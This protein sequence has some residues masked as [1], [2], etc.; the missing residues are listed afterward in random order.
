MSDERFTA[1]K[2]KLQNFNSEVKQWG[3]NTESNLKGNASYQMQSQNLQSKLRASF[4]KEST[5]WGKR[6]FNIGFSF[7]RE[8][9]FVHYGVG[10][11]YR[12]NNGTVERYAKN[13]TNNPRRP[14]N[15][16]NPVVKQKLPQLDTIVE[17]LGDEL[18]LNST[19]ILLP[20]N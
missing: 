2:A 4:R 15:W 5:P 16:F 6:T 13:P 12:R 14:K 20:E 17:T 11:G 8:G 3:G 10:R 1:L 9:V 19:R 18:V 7:P